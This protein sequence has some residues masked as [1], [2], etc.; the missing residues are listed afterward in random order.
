MFHL[1]LSLHR[2]PPTSHFRI[3]FLSTYTNLP[4]MVLCSFPFPLFSLIPFSRCPSPSLVRPASPQHL[5]DSRLPTDHITRLEGSAAEY[6]NR[7]L[8][9][10]RLSVAEI[11]P[12]IG[13]CQQNVLPPT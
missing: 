11:S 7:K 4:P 12:I 8:M 3:S 2:S 9:S 13:R 10:L 6:A 5:F 1:F